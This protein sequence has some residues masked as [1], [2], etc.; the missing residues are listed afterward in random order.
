MVV[1][2]FDIVRFVLGPDEADPVL[3]VDPNAVLALA[4]AREG[5]EAVAGRDPGDRRGS[6]TPSRRDFRL[7]GAALFDVELD[8]TAGV[9]IEDQ[10][11]SSRTMADALFPWIRG[12]R[13]DPLGLPPLQLATPVST[14]SQARRGA[15][16]LSN[17]ISRA[18]EC[19][20]SVITIRSPFRARFR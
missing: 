16:F 19:P 1:D 12:R 11:R 14:R 7:R 3:V 20:C 2:D 8:E 15:S 4:I 9:E 13:L 5:L 17:E 6:A 10:R 18:T